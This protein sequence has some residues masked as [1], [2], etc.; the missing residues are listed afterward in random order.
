MK[1]FLA[2]WEAKSLNEII[3]T[4][5][6]ENLFMSYYSL[7]TKKNILELRELLSLRRKRC[8]LIVLDSW[9]HTFF[10]ELSSEW[11]SVSVH[12][13]KTKTK[14]SPEIY[15]KNYLSWLKVFHPYI[16]YF[17]ELDIWEIVWQKKVEEWREE[18]K[19]AWLWNKCITAYHPNIMTDE[20]F[21]N[22]CKE[23]GSKY[24]WVEWDRPNRPRLP[25]N[26]LIKIARK[27]NVRL[28]WFAMTKKSVYFDYPFFSVDST[29]WLAWLQYWASITLNRDRQVQATRFKNKEHL[30]Q[31]KEKNTHLT[32]SKQKKTQHMLRALYAAKA[33]KVIQ[34]QSEYLWKERGI[35][36]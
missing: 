26:K 8:K 31:V 20:Y 34:E 24:I 16:D 23:S 4:W 5:I 12:T 18:I 17:V 25:Y 21:E 35:T 28:H 1:I 6:I 11:L 22:M 15:M 14:E 9:A 29:S 33:Y 2:W 32:H 10:S 13:K 19:K 3:E 30:L 36:Y 7:R 27:Y